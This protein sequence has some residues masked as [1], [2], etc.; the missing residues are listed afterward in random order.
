MNEDGASIA[1]WD[2]FSSSLSAE[3]FQKTGQLIGFRWKGSVE[4]GF[5]R[6]G[7]SLPCLKK[8]NTA[9]MN[10]WKPWAQRIL[11]KEQPLTVLWY[12]QTHLGNC[13]TVCKCATAVVYIILQFLSLQD[14]GSLQDAKTLILPRSRKKKYFPLWNTTLENCFYMTWISPLPIC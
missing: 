7:D 6:T 8:E 5:P 4:P 13:E 14:D 1:S 12:L 11:S 9:S 3:S 2:S 10:L